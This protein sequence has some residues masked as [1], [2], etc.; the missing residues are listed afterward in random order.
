MRDFRILTLEEGG[1]DI[2]VIDGQADYLAYEEQTQDQRAALAVYAIKGSLPGAP[3]YGV[4]WGLE[5]SNTNGT[6][7]TISNECQQQLA[8]Y[9]ASSTPTSRIVA[10]TYSATVI[11]R[12][13]SLGVLVA[14]GV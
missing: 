4:S 8:E 13:G 3:D 9:A 7:I 5:F 2:D 14:K 11:P 1:V 6:A 10:T 12:N